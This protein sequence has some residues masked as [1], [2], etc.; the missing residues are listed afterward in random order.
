[1]LI[2]KKSFQSFLSFRLFSS[3]DD[4]YLSNDAA[5]LS[6]TAS[7]FIL[8]ASQQTENLDFPGVVNNV[9]L[10][11]AL[12]KFRSE[13]GAFSADHKI[14]NEFRDE[15]AYSSDATMLRASSKKFK[16]ALDKIMA[17]KEIFMNVK[18]VQLEFMH[19]TFVR[20]LTL[21]SEIASRFIEGASKQTEDL[22]CQRL[23]A[24]V[25][26]QEAL[27]IFLSQLEAFRVNYKLFN[28]SRDKL[29][30]SSDETRLLLRASS[31]NFQ[32]ALNKIIASDKIFMDVK[33]TQLKCQTPKD[34]K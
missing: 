17:S 24:N 34:V 1:M 2:L 5:L 20:N 4:K 16:I 15:F 32:I 21:L 11:E 9:I 8:E 10:Q 27:K 18:K 26:F 6:E 13:L 23:V 3:Y 7:R 22:D 33:K 12:N 25:I 28:E 14:F 29:G 31:Q 30:D 19:Q